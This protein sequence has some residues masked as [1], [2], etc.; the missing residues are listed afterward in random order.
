[1]PKDAVAEKL[2]AAIADMD[3]IQ[4]VTQESTKP[5]VVMELLR[6]AKVFE[7]RNRVYGDNYKR[8]GAVM[9]LLME[10]QQ[11]VNL[12]DPVIGNRFGVLVQIVAKITRYCENFDRGGHDDS[13]DDIAVYAMMLK[14][15]DNSNKL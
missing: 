1:M 9:K 7:E 14:E 8:F 6:K 15:L 4:P 10:T 11:P 12:F 2:E 13:L 3:F 5:F